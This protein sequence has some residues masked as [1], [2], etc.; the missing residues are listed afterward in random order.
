[1]ARPEAG[2]VLLHE[3]SFEPAARERLA[4]SREFPT[5]FLE[6]GVRML[7]IN[8]DAFEEGHSSP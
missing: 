4:G 7:E 3:G 2:Y 6:S 8:R 1:M 5:I